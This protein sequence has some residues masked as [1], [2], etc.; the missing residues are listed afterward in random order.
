MLASL[1]RVD[2]AHTTYFMQQFYRQL[3]A[4]ASK[5]RALRHAQN[6]LRDNT[7]ALHPAF[8]GAFQLVGNPASLSNIPEA[9]NGHGTD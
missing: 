8:W 9:V 5:S 3:A 1:W 4:G 2:D 7:P 6:A